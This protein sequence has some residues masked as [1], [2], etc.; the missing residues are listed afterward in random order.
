MNTRLQLVWGR[1][2]RWRS[3]RSASAPTRIATES[4]N[5][6]ARAGVLQ[7]LVIGWNAFLASDAVQAL[8]RA[9]GATLHVAGNLPYDRAMDAVYNTVSR[10]GGGWHRLFDGGHSFV[11]AWKAIGEHRPDDRFVDAFQGYLVGLWNDVITPNGLPLMTFSKGQMDRIVSIIGQTGVDRAH[12]YDLVSF[13]ATEVAGGVAGIVLLAFN[14][15][16]NDSERYYELA[17]A[18]GVTG[19]AAANP[20]VLGVALCAALMGDRAAMRRKCVSRLRLAGASRGG[21]VAAGALAGAAVGLPVGL[22][23]AIP[24]AVAGAAIVQWVLAQI[25]R[26]Q[27]MEARARIGC[28]AFAVSNEVRA[29]PHKKQLLL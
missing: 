23:G 25:V 29:L 19:A 10:V 21:A 20:V 26:R 28:A 3:R 12:L 13:T 7:S 11:G 14:M 22:V 27:A 24:G 2:I 17:G 8:D 6:T 4:D 9:L 5:A 18:L 16:K 1:L 15:R